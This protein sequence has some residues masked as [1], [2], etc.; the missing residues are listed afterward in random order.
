MKM[1]ALVCS[2]FY[3]LSMSADVLAQ[4]RGPRYNPPGGGGS[5]SSG[6]SPSRSSGSSSSGS[7]SSPSRG[8]N[9]NPPS[10]SSGS[11]SGSSSSS[12]SPSRGSNYNPPSR[13]SGS[14]S[15]G[16]SSSPSRGSNYN[17]PSN[18]GSS[19]S[20]STYSPA[21]STSPRGPRYNPPGST[22]PGG[23]TYAPRGPRYNPPGSNHNPVHVSTT[24]IHFGGPRDYYTHVGHH[25]IYRRWVQYPVNYWY[26]D[27]Y[28]DIDGYPYYV[29]R[30]YRYR[31]NPVEMCQYEL[32]D[33]ENYTTVKVYPLQACTTAYDQCAG[34]R[35]TMN[36]TVAMERYFCAEAVDNDLAQAND[37]EYQGSAVEMT[38]AKKAAIAAYLEDMSFKDLYKDAANNGVG[39]C[40]ITN[41]GG[42]FGNRS[43]YDC[44]YQVNVGSKAYPAVNGSVCS[45]D[46]AAEAVD[47]AVGNEKENAGCILKQAIQSGYCH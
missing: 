10:R 15:S 28:W 32:V 31:Y 21:P 9:Y 5:S 40:T 20:G 16:S 12:S 23:T 34:E 14:S 25:Y 47:C 37:S 42:V 6:S 38:E 2:A 36:R 44:K 3:A 7:S 19:S 13:S 22:T 24:V 29:N 30:G 26:T 8:S 4:T 35:D 39:T 27:G 1:F 43:A 18:G 33:A 41:V 45:N 17:P 11:S 46:A